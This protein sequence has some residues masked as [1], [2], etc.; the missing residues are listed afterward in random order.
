[1]KINIKRT[2]HLFLVNPFKR[3]EDVNFENYYQLLELYKHKVFPGD[4][5]QDTQTNFEPGDIRG[6]I[7]ILEVIKCHRTNRIYYKTEG[8]DFREYSRET[9]Y[10]Y[11]FSAAEI[12]ELTTPK[13]IADRVIYKLKEKEPRYLNS[14]QLSQIIKP[15]STSIINKV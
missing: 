11:R 6:M 4:L 14:F 5:I 9:L 3:W 1:M 8:N 7:P 12:Y 2:P 10:Q 15:A 13:V